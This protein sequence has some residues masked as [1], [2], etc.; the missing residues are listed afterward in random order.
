MKNCI[1]IAAIATIV[2]CAAYVAKRVKRS[3]SQKRLDVK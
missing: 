2:V 1:K 3:K